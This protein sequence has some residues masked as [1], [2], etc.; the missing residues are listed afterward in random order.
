MIWS[1]RKKKEGNFLYRFFLPKGNIF[2]ISFISM[3]SAL[4]I[5]SEYTYFY[6]SK[7]ITSYTFL[8]A[9]EIVKRLQCI[10][11]TEENT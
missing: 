7:N 5:L 3:Y 1:S 9:F 2:I 11:N 10:L 8:L 4:N 6:I